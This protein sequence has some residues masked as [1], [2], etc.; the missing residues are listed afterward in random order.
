[1]NAEKAATQAALTASQRPCMTIRFPV[2]SEESIGQFLML[3]E[4][5]ATIV[6]TL[7]N[8]DP[9]DQPAV[10]LGKDYTYALMGKKGYQTTR[11]ELSARLKGGSQ[12]VV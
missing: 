10:Q 9:Y 8:I 3:W 11:K 2:V 4:A 6:G 5:A 1:M 7:L 12:F